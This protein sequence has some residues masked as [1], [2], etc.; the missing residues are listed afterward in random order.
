MPPAIRP[1]ALIALVLASIGLTPPAMSEGVC[2]L[3][4]DQRGPVT[5]PADLCGVTTVHASSSSIVR[6]QLAQDLTIAPEQAR[7]T[8]FEL[9][10]AGASVAGFVLIAADGQADGILVGGWHKPGAVATERFLIGG[11][12]ILGATDYSA[13]GIENSMASVSLGAGTYHLSV[14]SNGGPISLTL[15]LPD[16]S[17][18]NEMDAVT[19]SGAI[20]RVPDPGVPAPAPAVAS[21]VEKLADWGITIGAIRVDAAAFGTAEYVLCRRRNFPENS[22]ACGDDQIPEQSDDPGLTIYTDRGNPS[23]SAT[24]R[25]L[26]HITGLNPPGPFGM[27]FLSATQGAVQSR[28]FV[29]AWVPLQAT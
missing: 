26:T 5:E 28:A 25:T 15:N 27:G 11:H 21:T 17:G 20:V 23:P 18:W 10:S 8:L 6:L 9:T 3:P 2:D 22:H 1:A 7:D 24:T 13:P 29:A 4:Q 12:P 16:L 19:P 14:F